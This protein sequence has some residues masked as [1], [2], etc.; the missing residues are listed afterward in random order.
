V[1]LIACAN[2]ANLLLART[3][4]RRR[5]IATRL[6]LGASRARVTRQLL[7]ESA[8][9]ALA[10]ATLGLLIA[11]FGGHSLL[12]ILSAGGEGALGPSPGPGGTGSI[13]L[14]IAPGAS[15]LMFTTVLAIATVILFGTAPALAATRHSPGIGHGAGATVTGRARTGAVLV[16]VQISLTLLLLICSGLFVQTLQNLRGFD[17]GFD[18]QGVLLVDVDGRAAGYSGS[19]LSALCRDLHERMERLPGVR[20]ASYSG[21]PPL[22]NGETSY[23]FRVNGETTTEESLYLTIGPRYFETMRTPLLAG[24]EFT[25]T[26]TAAAPKVAI[27][28]ETFVRLHLQGLTPLGQRLSIGDGNSPPMEIVGVVRDALFSGSV[29]YF[30]TPSVAF[31]P[32]AQSSPSRATFE[33]AVSGSLREVTATLRRELL[34]HL[35]NVRIEVRSMGEQLDR[36]LLQER[37]V[38]GLG[39]TLGVLALLLAIV[40]LYGLLAYN[41]TRRTAEI[42][43]RM[44]LGATRADVLRLVIRD[45]VLALTA[46]VTVGAPLAWLASSMFSHMLF[47]VTAMDPLTVVT[48]IAALVLAGTAAAYTP[49]RR[50][51][52]VDPLVAVRSE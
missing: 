12:T 4:A 25:A 34:I 46:G 10:G 11:W 48:A 16:T 44:A 42:G 7:T 1:L 17:R 3:A 28:N 37:L 5:E 19:P 41:V 8:L 49:A 39:G 32:Y 21:R 14:D 45:A 31:V 38:A 18:P 24:R 9:L 13:V 52:K 22:A 35:P 40:G 43:V 27:V 51:M 30:V 23:D 33:V 6:A 26:D 15:V 47:G 50:A 2:L 20:A 36:A 29:R